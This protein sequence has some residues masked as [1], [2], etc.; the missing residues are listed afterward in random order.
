VTRPP[1]LVTVDVEG[2]VDQGS[3][4]SV[5]VL[6]SSLDALGL[7]AT[8]FVTPAVVE[9]RPA[10]VREWVA[11]DHAVGLHVHPGRLGGDSDWLE[12]YD[13]ADLVTFLDRGVA[14]FE[15]ELGFTPTSFRGGRWS[16]SETLLAA[17]DDRGFTVDAT[18]RP[19]GRL[20]AYRYAGVTE[21][22][23]TVVGNP[24]FRFLLRRTGIDGL[25]LHADAFLETR[26]RAAALYAA[27]TAVAASD[28]PYL[29]TS[30]HDYDIIDGTLR[31]RVERYLA[32]LSEWCRPATLATLT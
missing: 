5:D 7:P 27:T 21:Y 29:M 32:R 3:F 17:L 8:L 16:F 6:A 9:H 30:L 23:M 14:V 24:V 1:L 31:R 13:L 18:H 11:G 25:P 15:D 22:P 20:D 10:I 26:P 12:T 2:I 4:E 19:G 28:R